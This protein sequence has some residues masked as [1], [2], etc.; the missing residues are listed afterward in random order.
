MEAMVM[1]WASAISREWC[2]TGFTKV[3]LARRFGLNV[4]CLP[5]L[6]HHFLPF[7]I[8][9][10]QALAK[11]TTLVTLMYQD[12][13]LAHSIVTHRPASNTRLKRFREAADAC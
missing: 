6:G 5:K 11:T 13:A 4:C 1:E 9:V 2:I 10:L 7:A 12:L 8:H 3:I